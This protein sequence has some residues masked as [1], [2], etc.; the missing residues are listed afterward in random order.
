M[1]YY[2]LNQTDWRTISDIDIIASTGTTNDSGYRNKKTFYGKGKHPSEVEAS[3]S[4]MRLK[5]A[6]HCCS[7]GP[8]KRARFLSEEHGQPVNENIL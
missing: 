5:I 2:L 7:H 1:F 3:S 4:D 6:Q 8:A